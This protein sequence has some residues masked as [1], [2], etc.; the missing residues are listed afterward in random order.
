VEAGAGVSI[1]ELET[2][3]DLLFIGAGLGRAQ[4]LGVP[5][6]DLPG[7]V[8]ALEF[9]A[10]Y[11]TRGARVG[12]RVAVIGGGNTAMDAAVAARRLGAE[13]VRILYRRT[14][15]EMPAFRFEYERALRD[16]VIFQFLTRPVAV[17]GKGAVESLE[18]VRMEPVPPGTGARPQ[19]REI[20]GSNFT[21]ECDM[22][23]PSIGQS[24]VVSLLEKCRGIE[25]DSGMVRVEEETCRTS[26]PRYYAGGD[27]VNG[28]KEVVDAVADGKRAACAM[29][30]RLEE[31]HG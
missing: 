23:I 6:Q 14:G 31:M 27:C 5:G 18:C 16:G 13:E 30:R 3:F 24:R 10:A 26:N 20:D 2:E 4:P 12:R 17:R 11:K 22:V 29:A 15:K 7:V 8:D 1:E 21:L 25:V 9:I 19:P 28:G